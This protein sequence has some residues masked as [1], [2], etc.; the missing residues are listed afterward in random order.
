[1]CL[2]FNIEATETMLYLFNFATDLIYCRSFASF[3]LGV[4][5]NF[6]TVALFAGLNEV[7]KELEYPYR[8]MVSL[9]FCPFLLDFSS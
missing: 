3:W 7:S 6:F 9:L 8:C 4:F 2:S 5:F 1:M